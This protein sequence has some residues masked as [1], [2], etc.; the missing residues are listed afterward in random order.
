MNQ[1]VAPPA[2]EV[3]LP[4]TPPDQFERERRAF[5]RLLPDLLNSHRGQFVAI[6]DEKVVDT[7][8]DRLQLALRVQARVKAGVYVGHVTDEAEPIVRSG[9]RRALGGWRAGN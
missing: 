4:E 6:H 1:T 7:G 5:H 8:P 2:I 9:I 3:R